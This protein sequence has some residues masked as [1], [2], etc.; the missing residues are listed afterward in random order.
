MLLLRDEEGCWVEDKDKLK[1]LAVRYFENLYHKER[2]TSMNGLE[3]LPNF[4]SWF[5]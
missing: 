2:S 4:F 1:E 5:G 3:L